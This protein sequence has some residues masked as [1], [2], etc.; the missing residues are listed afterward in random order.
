MWRDTWNSVLLK[1]WVI[2]VF[3]ANSAIFQLYHGENKLII[4]EMMMKSTLYQT[5]MLSLV[6]YSASSLKQQSAGRHVAPLGHIIL[7]PSQPVFALS[8]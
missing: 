4:N 2:V 1:E 5:N 3:K 6:F 8:P 7:I